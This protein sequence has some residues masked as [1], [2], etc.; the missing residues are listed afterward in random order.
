[1]FILINYL[2]LLKIKNEINK[3]FFHINTVFFSNEL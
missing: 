1:L 3:N 2:F